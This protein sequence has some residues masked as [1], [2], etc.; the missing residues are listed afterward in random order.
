MAATGSQ[1]EILVVALDHY[2]THGKWPTAIALARLAD[3][4]FPDL[5]RELKTLA[6]L[7]L[8]SWERSVRV[9]RMPDG[10]FLPIAAENFLSRNTEPP[11]SSGTPRGCAPEADRYGV[12]S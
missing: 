9:L 6:R 4:A 5:C 10:L 11:L 2:A 12:T 3:V 8:V 7:G 1:R